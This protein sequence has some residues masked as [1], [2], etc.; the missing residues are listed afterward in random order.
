MSQ[1][2]SESMASTTDHDTPASH[3]FL[4]LPEERCDSTAWAPYRL[5]FAVAEMAIDALLRRTPGVELGKKIVVSVPV[6]LHKIIKEN[7]DFVSWFEYVLE[8][9][10]GRMLKFAGIKGSDVVFDV[11]QL[12]PDLPK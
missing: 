8:G 4:N 7:P 2:P 9:V 11:T 6:S 3:C 1:E 12:D 10:W 5:A